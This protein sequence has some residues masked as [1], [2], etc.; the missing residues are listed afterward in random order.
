M[1]GKDHLGDQ[2]VNMRI[3]LNELLK[4]WD[5][6]VWTGTVRLRRRTSGSLF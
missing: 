5:M 6:R 2:E 1:N 4:K 3:I